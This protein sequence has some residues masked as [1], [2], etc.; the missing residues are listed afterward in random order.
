[1]TETNTAVADVRMTRVE[2]SALVPD[3][4]NANEHPDENIAAIHAS[5]LEFGQ[6]DPLI[7]QKESRRVIAGNARLLVMQSMGMTHANVIELDVSDERAIALGL[8]HNHTGRLARWNAPQVLKLIGD[9]EAFHPKLAQVVGFS[10]DELSMLTNVAAKEER[11]ALE[12]ATGGNE[13]TDEDESSPFFRQMI[14]DNWGSPAW[15]TEL[16]RRFFGGSPD[17]DPASDEARNKVV[18]AK[19]WLGLPHVDPAAG[20]PI[21]WGDARTVWINPPGGKHGRSTLAQ[22]FWKKAVEHHKTTGATIL[23]FAYSINQ[24][25]TLQNADAEAMNKT[26]MCVLR[27]RVAFEDREGNPSGGM[28]FPSAIFVLSQHHGDFD[29]F[30]E[31]FS[32]HGSA[33]RASK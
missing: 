13:A 22:V 3:P 10:P 20:I 17:L 12:A 21:D 26:H 4:D 5:L 24:L 2:L 6:V 15:V 14:E 28:T 25:Q 18:G 1:M 16:A 32:E 29:R 31:V 19:R 33:W 9:L 30:V 27:S 23:W 8:A 11:A 7:V